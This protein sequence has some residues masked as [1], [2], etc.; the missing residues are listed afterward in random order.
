MANKPEEAGQSPKDITPNP[1]D[2]AAKKA[3]AAA[4]DGTAP[5]VEGAAAVDTTPQEPP[6]EPGPQNIK[7]LIKQSFIDSI[8]WNRIIQLL[9]VAVGAFGL[10]IAVEGQDFLALPGFLGGLALILASVFDIYI[11]KKFRA[12]YEK[13]EITA[14]IALAIVLGLMTV[15]FAVEIYDK[16]RMSM[17]V[18]KYILL[19]T[20]AAVVLVFSINFILY[21]Q[22]NKEKLLADIYMFVSVI[23]ALLAVTVFGMNYVVVSFAIAAL[24]MIALIASVVNDPLKDDDR[25]QTRLFLSGLSA[26][27]FLAVLAYAATIFFVKPLP[28]ITYGPVTDTY[29]QRPVKLGWSGDSWSFDYGLYDKKE[30]VGRIGIINALSL[31]VTELPPKEDKLKLPHNTDAAVWNK[32]GSSLIFTA[33][34][35]ET[36]SR[37]IWAVALNLSLV[38]QENEKA[39]K[40]KEE[41]EK[42]EKEAAE[43]DTL[44]GGLKSELKEKAETLTGAEEKHELKLRTEEDD[45]LNKPVGKPKVLFADMNLIVEKDCKPITHRTAWSPDGRKFCFAAKDEKSSDFNIWSADVKSQEITKLT[46]GFNKVMPLWSPSGEKILWCSKTDSYTYLKISDYNGKNARE[47]DV[48]RARDRALFPLWNNDES[49]VIYVKNGRFIV[50]N[51]NAT[52]QQDLNRQTFPV[53]PYWL[54]ET[55]KKVRLEFT[56]SGVIWRVWTMNTEGK[57]VKNIFT[58]RCESLAQPKWDYEGKTIALAANYENG[59]STVFRLSKD[60][61][62]RQS[63]FTTKANISELEWANSSERLAFLAK[64]G[65]EKEAE[66][67]EKSNF[68]EWLAAQFGNLFSGEEN[69]QEL[70]IIENDGTEPRPIYETEGQLNNISWNDLGNRIAFDETIKRPY[71]INPITV[72]KVAEAR[73]DEE[74]YSLL[75]YEFNGQYPTWSN[76]GQVLAYVSWA[77]Y[78]TPEISLPFLRWGISVGDR[79]WAAK[80]E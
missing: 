68:S 8:V 40:E 47:L 75:P 5:A 4:A 78:W 19:G 39:R 15:T 30:K 69:L 67:N 58:E 62:M 71:F 24:S 7:E 48:N 46:R 34:G 41:K 3:E 51:A 23:T 6:E 44:I 72:V 70:W 45:R 18:N 36:G 33:G 31:G 79:I 53:S 43:K 54:T 50:M 29:K 13:L 20:M 25:L 74:V 26:L 61:D 38:E 64:H 12:K 1:M 73:G 35:E 49:R 63:L 32:N 52:N 59:T 10:Y 77:E 2:E 76:D 21:I 57:K 14:R 60:G 11:I 66:K 65:T 27:L 22:K 56:E 37:S 80:L 42:A 17:T 28:I 9:F 55:K 16:L